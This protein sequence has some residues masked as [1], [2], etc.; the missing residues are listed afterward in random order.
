[1][2]VAKNIHKFYEN[3]HILKGIDIKI[4]EGEIVSLIGSSGAGKTTLLQILSTIEKYEA[5]YNSMLSLNGI[6]LDTLNKNEIAKLRNENLGFVFQFHELLPEFTV[7]ENICIPAFIKGISKKDAQREADKLIDYF[8][9]SN[10]ANNKPS[11]ISGGEKQRVAVAR[12]LINSP[13][14]IFADEPSGN[15]DSQNSQNLY[16]YFLKLRKDFKYT[17]LIATHDQKLAKKSDRVIKIN[18]GQIIS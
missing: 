3:K 11:E 9:I 2:I 16:E 12:A 10:I 14:V 8:G 17:F 7:I 15:L 13:K 4:D 18:D 1:M 5:G 6:N